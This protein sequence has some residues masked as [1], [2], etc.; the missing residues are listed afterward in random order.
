M[1]CKYLKEVQDFSYLV[2]N[3]DTLGEDL[4]TLINIWRLLH[5]AAPKESD[6]SIKPTK[7][8][9]KQKSVS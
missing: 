5:G 6:I 3:E 7:V 4:G 8:E 2:E 1:F 9:S